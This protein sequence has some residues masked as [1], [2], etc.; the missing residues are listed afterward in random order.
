MR[1]D[2][3]LVEDFTHRALRQMGK[4]RISLR[5][6][7]LTGM[8]GEKPGRPQ[9][10]R[11]AQV[12]RFPACQR[13]QPSFGFERDRRFPTGTRAIVERGHRAF[14]YG[15]LDATLNC[16]MVKPQCPTN[17]KKRRILPIGQQYSRPLD[18]ACRL[19][20]RLRYRVQFGRI[21]IPERQFNRPPPRCHDFHPAPCGLTGPIWESNQPE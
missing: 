21:L 9:F 18:P 12:L 15:A 16:L 11:I 10:V 6:S 17:R 3:F 19:G 4:A 8:A 7:V 1:L 14:D 5:R 20:S 13:H 2:F